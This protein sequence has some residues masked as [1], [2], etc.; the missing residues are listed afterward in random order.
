[1]NAI[2]SPATA[3]RSAPLRGFRNEAKAFAAGAWFMALN[4]HPGAAAWCK[5]NGIILTRAQAEGVNSVGGF[6]VPDE[7]M[8]TVIALR[9][10][11]GVFRAAADVTP[12]TRDNAT[13]PRRTSGLTAYFSAEA[14]ALTESQNAFDNVNLTTKKLT[15][16]TRTSSE[17]D[18][19]SA[20]DLGEW[21]PTE[22]A[23]AFASKEDDCGFNGD[24]SSTYGGIRGLTQLFLDP[25]HSHLDAI[26]KTTLTL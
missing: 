8:R 1:M 11:R 12:L 13:V 22:M 10:L 14:A 16:F 26:P 18:E 24:G 3:L 5:E 21:F 19:D 20:I 25:R 6:L 17:F 2:F 15:T 4:E 7:I 9:E 23:Y